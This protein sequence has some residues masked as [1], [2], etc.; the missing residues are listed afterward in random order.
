MPIYK[1]LKKEQEEHDKQMIEIIKDL[2]DKENIADDREVFI[3][4]AKETIYREEEYKA[5]M[6]EYYF[7]CETEEAVERLIKSLQNVE[8][9]VRVFEGISKN[10]IKELVNKIG[11]CAEEVK[12]M[13][14]TADE[15]FENLDYVKMCDDS[16]KVVY[17]TFCSGE[18]CGQIVIYKKDF[19]F[20]VRLKDA[21]FRISAGIDKAIHKKIEELKNEWWSANKRIIFIFKE[22]RVIKKE[23]EKEIDKLAKDLEEEM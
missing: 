18:S 4:E 11:I 7:I 16:I 10:K 15:M 6:K 22:K 12:Q 3:V 19:S 20:A 21:Y 1:E 2:L 14:K 9:E 17:E 13:N 8:S 5:E 23:K